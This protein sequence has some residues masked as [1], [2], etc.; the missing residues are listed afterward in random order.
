MA[1][2]PLAPHV[3]SPAE[4]KERIEAERGGKPFLVWRDGDGRQRILAL[5]DDAGHVTVG[6][7]SLNDVALEWDSEVSRVHA[8]FEQ[9]AGEW[10]I[11]DDGLSANGSYVN[12]ERLAGRRRLRDGDALRF[13]ST[14]VAF[15]APRRA[16]SQATK[17]VQELSDVLKITDAQRRVL[18]GLCEPFTGPSRFATPASNKEIADQLH[19]SVDAVKTHMRRL[20]ELFG[21]ADLPQRE[22]RLRLVERAFEVG[23]VSPGES[24]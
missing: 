9:L 13:G 4:L 16:W 5:E 23:L 8:E 21:L 7:R 19:I 6:R 3:A 2:S 14:V 17:V 18:V 22:K 10:T 20:Y 15:R 12:G 1:V 24:D 11:T